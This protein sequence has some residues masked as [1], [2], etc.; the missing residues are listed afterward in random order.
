VSPDRN[1]LFGI[2]ALQNGFVTRDQLVEAMNSWALARHRPLGE[3]LRERGALGEEEHALLEALVNLQLAK[4]QGNVENSLQALGLSATARAALS[5]VPAVDLQATLAHLAT[6]SVEATTDHVELCSPLAEGTIDHV[7]RESDE[8]RRYRVLRPH[9]RGGLGEVFVAED[10]QLHR[11]V[12]LKEIQERHAC[13]DGSR[14]RFLLEA[15][16]T[17]RLEHP[18]IV[19]VYGLGCHAD[20]RPF[21]AMRFIK[22]DN[23]KS[24]IESF[25]AARTG[26]DTLAFRQVLRRFLDTCNAIAYAHSR[27][28]LHR[29]V[30]PGNVMLGEFGETL[31]VD[32]GLAKVI[33]K[34]EGGR[35]KDEP[36][37]AGPEPL[38]SY[39]LHP[40]SFDMTMSG[41]AIGTPAYMSPEQAEG[42]LDLLGPATDV[43]SLGATLYCVLTGQAPVTEGEIADVLEKV[44]RGDILPANQ[45]R[46][47]VPRPLAAICRKAMALQP[48]GRYASALALAADVEHWLADEPVSAYREPAW[49]R[50]G[51]WAR[52]HRTLVTTA[53]AVLLVALAGLS[54][55][56]VVVGGLNRRLESANSALKE[57]NYDLEQARAEAEDKHRE[58]ERERN[59][60]V[61]V[62]DF[63]Q[64]DLLGQAD[65]GNQPF[66]G[67][68]AG[69]NPN[70]TVVELLDRAAKAIDAKFKGQPQTEAAIRLTIGGAYQALGKYESAQAHL[71]RAAALREAT[72]GADHVYTLTAKNN[73]ALL[74]HYQ[75]KHDKAEPL[76]AHVLRQREQQL[77]PDHFETLATK[78]N[79]AS[80]YRDQ[81]KFDKAETLFLELLRQQERT[82]GAGHANTL[83]T[84]NA[85][86]GLF[87]IQRKYD[88]AEPLFEEVMEHTEKQLGPDH[89]EAMMSKHNLACVYRD[90]RKYD[91]A[92]TLFI[93]FLR[94]AEKLG[95]DHPDVLNGKNSLGQL[96]SARGENDRA[97]ALFQEAVTGATKKLGFAH[98]RTQTYFHEL[99]G[100]Y[101]RAGK[102]AKAQPFLQQQVDF[103]RAGAG[104]ESAWGVAALEELAKCLLAQKDHAGAEKVLQECLRV[105]EKTQPDR[106]TTFATRSALGGALTNLK[107]YADAEPQLLHGYRGLDERATQI[108]LQFRN[109][110]LRE[111]LVRLVR[112]YEA[113][114][115]KDEAEKWKKKLDEAKKAD[116]KPAR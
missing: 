65:I 63:L 101:R 33:Q 103:L 81:G 80:A 88:K 18:G 87:W 44:R 96:Y 62:N 110:R 23:L 39:I 31:V 85:L 109:A 99:I 100:L 7:K 76:Y 34:D 27:G 53:A 10:T 72:L 42:R 54:L 14:G 60:A 4:H 59:V 30:K 92:E 17:G 46:A 95:A 115:K 47:D 28:V 1:L 71:E 55:G 114:G 77:G 66:A 105:S 116:A 22:G 111:A 25:H 48:Q 82:L 84:K 83:S 51:R 74:Y 36:N 58:A 106:W 49:V 91:E 57:S 8:E 20:G 2:L 45:V 67:E 15:E 21:Y 86:G 107:K 75:A 24:A 26:F 94:Q 37:Q 38:S 11:E 89:P 97:E 108:P 6:P 90:Q 41:A 64:Q 40:S 68:K 35:M 9:A 3:V 13:D 52:K 73:L 19:P 29:D 98:P 61:A 5:V 102:P 104:L 93:Q 70:I 78:H 79:L 56:L 112:L 12:A 50:M 32:W 69:R 16:I 113:T 43:Y